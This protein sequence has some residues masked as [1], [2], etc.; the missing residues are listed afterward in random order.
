MLPLAMVIVT[1]G[2]MVERAAGVARSGPLLQGQAAPMRSVKVNANWGTRR[3]RVRRELRLD[4]GR[5]AGGQA[6][7]VE[8][9]VLPPVFLKSGVHL[10]TGFCENIAALRF[11]ES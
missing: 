4:E 9:R 5:P 7:L 1:G 6:V 8:M 3:C 11:H 10:S 2:S